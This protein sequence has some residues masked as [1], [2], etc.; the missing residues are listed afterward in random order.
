[1]TFSF[2]WQSLFG[3]HD[4]VTAS[5]AFDADVHSH[6]D[7]FPAVCTTWMGLFHF[8]NIIQCKGLWLHYAFL[9]IRYQVFFAFLHGAEF[10]LHPSVNTSPCEGMEFQYHVHPGIV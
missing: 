3:D 9:L 5:D 6:T 7:Y 8:Y 10:L 4:A 1:M 2:S